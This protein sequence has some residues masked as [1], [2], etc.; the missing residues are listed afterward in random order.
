MR[1]RA[2]GPRHGLRDTPLTRVRD[3]F[4]EPEMHPSESPGVFRLLLP[5][6]LRPFVPPFLAAR[7][8]LTHVLIGATN[9]PL[10]E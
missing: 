2:C 8:L 5:S 3:L 6:C 7:N 9:P 4:E 10:G 1:Q